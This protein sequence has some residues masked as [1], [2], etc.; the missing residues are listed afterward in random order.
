MVLGL[1]SGMT[2]GEALL[3][4]ITKLDV[5]E[6][7]AEAVKACQIFTPW[8]NDCLNDPRTQ[9]IVQDG[10]NHLALTRNTYDVIISEPSNPWMAGL[11]N[12]YTLEF[13]QTVKQRLRKPG[14]FV[15]WVHSYEMDWPTFALIG[16]TF[17]RVFKNSLLLTTVQAD[18]LLVGFSGQEGFDLAVGEEN[19]KYAQR[20]KNVSIANARLPFQ[21]IIAE[22]LK[23]FFGPGPLHTDTWPRLE[24]SA[25]R[26]LHRYDLPSQVRMTTGYGVSAKTKEILETG[27]HIDSILDKTEFAASAHTPHLE[28]PDLQDTSVCQRERLQGI[29]ERYC[30]ETH[31]Q[32]YEM[33]PDHNMKADCAEHQVKR[34]RQH[35][36]IN[37]DDASGY[38]D[39]GLALEQMN[40]AEKA[41]EALQKAISLNPYYVNAYNRVGL[42]MTRQGRLE[43]ALGYFREVLQIKPGDTAAKQN[44][45][46]ILRLSTKPA[47]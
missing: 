1:A 11:A 25:P 45:E 42:I 41:I 3:Y 32:N 17:S 30:T 35:L 46:T 28:I 26:Q 7:N 5:I 44:M 20:S 8:N 29:L 24:F 13:F 31:V 39:L 23:A 38:Y 40:M 43:E 6:I 36:A 4:P 47:E 21:M 2:A 16:R 12:L 18:H 33:F 19:I 15:Q 10:R 22:D 9:I 14:I 34:I 37:R 27:N